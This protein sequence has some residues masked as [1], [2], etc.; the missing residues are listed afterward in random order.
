MVLSQPR[1]VHCGLLACALAIA[2]AGAVALTSGGSR[3]PVSDAPSSSAIRASGVAATAHEALPSQAIH[4][5][6][7]D[8]SPLAASVNPADQR[9]LILYFVIKAARPTPMFSH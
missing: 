3:D 6:K 9:G 4:R 5:H 8:A 7:R 2:T 1:V